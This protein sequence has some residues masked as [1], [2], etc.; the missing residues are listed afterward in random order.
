MPVSKEIIAK[1]L[2]NATRDLA[3]P[4]R[5]LATRPAVTTELDAKTLRLAR[6]VAAEHDLPLSEVIGV[7][8]RLALFD[9]RLARR[10]RGALE[11]AAGSGGPRRRSS[12]R[13]NS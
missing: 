5:D 6:Q 10:L 11:R 2:R 13:D 7:A 4:R 1:A 8:V 3:K 12:A 9:A